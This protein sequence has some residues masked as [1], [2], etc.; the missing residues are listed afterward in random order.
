MLPTNDNAPLTSRP[1]HL[2]PIV[3]FVGDHGQVVITDP[4]WRPTSPAEVQALFPNE[5]REA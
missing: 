3:G 4:R 1:A 2:V 5:T